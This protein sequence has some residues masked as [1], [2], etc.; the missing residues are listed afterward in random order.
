MAERRLTAHVLPRPQA[1]RIA[2]NRLFLAALSEGTLRVTRI[3]AKTLQHA[4]SGGHGGSE[5]LSLA[6]VLLI[7]KIACEVHLIAAERHSPSLKGCKLIGEAGN[8]TYG[9]HDIGIIPLIFKGSI[10]IRCKRTK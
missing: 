3:L 8:V 4:V 7:R 10:L 5:R 2:G 1:A 6:A 9:L